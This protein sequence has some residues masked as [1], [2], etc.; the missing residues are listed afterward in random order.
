MDKVL[1]NMISLFCVF[2]NKIIR[3]HLFTN[4]KVLVVFVFKTLLNQN[5]MLAY[6]KLS[7]QS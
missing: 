5:K 3:V 2:L 4:I 7:Y 6:I 1:T